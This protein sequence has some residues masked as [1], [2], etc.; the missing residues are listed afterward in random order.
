MASD[1]K[2]R[3]MGAAEKFDYKKKESPCPLCGGIR[4]WA[5]VTN[6]MAWFCPNENC[7]PVR[8]AGDP[9]NKNVLRQRVPPVMRG[10]GGGMNPSSPG[11]KNEA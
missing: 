7:P 3:K 9:D 1:K 11:K 2:A 4:V 6:T 5:L 8:A 10:E